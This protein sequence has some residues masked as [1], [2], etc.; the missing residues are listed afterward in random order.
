VQQP[1]PI[2]PSLD[3]T[4]HVHEAPAE[5][6]RTPA[7]G[8]PSSAA[9][10]PR[11]NRRDALRSLAAEL[12]AAAAGVD[13][14]ADLRLP[15]TPSLSLH[16]V[17]QPAVSSWHDDDDMDFADLRLALSSE[18]VATPEEQAFAMQVEVR[19]ANADADPAAHRA[20]E[21]A[22]AMDAIMHAVDA[23]A[24][25]AHPAHAVEAGDTSSH[26]DSEALRIA[27]QLEKARAEAEVLA[28]R[29]EAESAARAAAERRLADAADE[30][31]FLRDELQMKGQKRRR[32]SPLRRLA[33]LLPG[34]RRP[35]LPAGKS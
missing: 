23:G 29:I 6:G 7:H 34:R 2:G 10:G 18:A 21:T 16:V 5:P 26:V 3:V 25:H 33:R 19:G 28:A 15:D 27:T 13:E 32:R 24:M 9:R 17:G 11:S 14:T 20:P 22:Q 30:L 35:V 1:T 4:S 31:R 8:R 12:S